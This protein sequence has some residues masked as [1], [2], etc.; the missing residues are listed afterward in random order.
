MIQPEPEDI[1]LTYEDY[2]ELPSDGKRYEIIDG[3]LHVAPAPGAN[4]H[5][6]V[7]VRLCTRLFNHIEAHDLGSVLPSPVDVVLSDYDVVQPDIVFVA[8][9]RLGIIGRE[10]AGP[11]DLTVEIISPGS[12]RLDRTVKRKLYAAHGVRYYWVVDPRSRRLEEYELAGSAYRLRS[13]TEEM[14]T[15]RPGL[16]PDLEI[17]LGRIWAQRESPSGTS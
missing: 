13:R 7:L 9:E 5:Q 10:I 8:R 14:D 12:A 2:M 1:R 15:F 3:E 11:P 6:T 4:I 17:P 16:F